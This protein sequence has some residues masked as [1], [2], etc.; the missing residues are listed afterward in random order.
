[1]LGDV[2]VRK[3]L[4]LPAPTHIKAKPVS[5]ILV[6][7]RKKWVSPQ[8][9]LVKQSN[10]ISVEVSQNSKFNKYTKKITY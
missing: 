7:A 8:T 6:L 4:V 10:T 5:L 9:M 3:V 2:S 1:M